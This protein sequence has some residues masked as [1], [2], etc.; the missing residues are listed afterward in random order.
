[1]LSEGNHQEQPKENSKE[2]DYEKM[3]SDF[4]KEELVPLLEEAKQSIEIA[5]QRAKARVEEAI[6]TGDEE[7]ERRKRIHV[8]IEKL[9]AE[10]K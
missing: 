9:L 6:K 3:F 10:K 4:S 2:E 7:V 5:K 1:M 8:A